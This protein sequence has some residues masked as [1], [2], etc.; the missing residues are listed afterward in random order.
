MTVAQ[1]SAPAA[2]V[3]AEIATTEVQVPVVA[4]KPAEDPDFSR[5]FAALSR[6]ERQLLER[7]KQ[8][9]AQISDPSYKEYEQWKQLKADPRRNA[10]TI[11]ESLGVPLSDFYQDLTGLVLNDGKPT[12]EQELAALRDQIANDKKSDAEAKAT[13]SQQRDEALIK[14][15]QQNLLSVTDS[16]PDEFELIKAHADEGSYELAFQVAL[17]L[18][19]KEKVIPDP[20]RVCKM[21]EEHLLGRSKK[22]LALKKLSGGPTPQ[23]NASVPEKMV[24]SKAPPAQS[25]TLTNTMNA[26]AKTPLAKAEPNL[27]D[28][29]VRRR[30]T[31]QKLREKALAAA[32]KA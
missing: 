8:I 25:K 11:V 17:H 2:P 12:V 9:K 26:V 29:E 24:E 20:T 28:P 6:K 4:E 15:Y 7:E 16:D 27:M 18:L 3:V 21:V 10:K 30:W 13:A 23:E 32:N 5:K 14:Q 31:A 1:V 22:L 19:Q